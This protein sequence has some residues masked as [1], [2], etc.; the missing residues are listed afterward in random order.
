MHEGMSKFL[1]HVTKHLIGITKRAENKL[2]NDFLLSSI[3]LCFLII[4]IG[5]KTKQE[6]LVV[7]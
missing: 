2:S 1:K 5:E 4:I 6:A 7:R 3:N